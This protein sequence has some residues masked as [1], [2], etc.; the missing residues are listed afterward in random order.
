MGSRRCGGACDHDH[1]SET[2]TTR[3]GAGYATAAFWRPQACLF[4]NE[5][6][7]LTVFVALAPAATLAERFRDALS[8]VLAAHGARREFIAAERAEME[9]VRLAKTTNRTVVGIMNEFIFLAKAHTESNAT[10]HLLKL[11]V[12]L[13]GTPC[14]PLYKRH[15]SPDRELAALLA[16]PAATDAR[17]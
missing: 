15:I 11:S 4:V 2:S 8:N 14:G 16:E 6:T 5:A 9:Q 12:R 10:P 17:T 3:L 7:L 1:S 13:A